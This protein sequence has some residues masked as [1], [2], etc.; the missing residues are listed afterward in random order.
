MYCLLFL[1]FFNV[2]FLFFP[3]SYILG[4]VLVLLHCHFIIIILG[5]I[6][7]ITCLSSEKFKKIGEGGGFFFVN[8]FYKLSNLFKINKIKIT[9]FLF[10]FI[11]FFF[12]FYFLFFLFFIFF[13]I[14]IIF[15]CVNF[16]KILNLMTNTIF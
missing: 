16:C 10:Y 6:K 14:I 3:L 9:F 13:L 5:R 7:L 4:I 11:F 8:V 15:L 1:V 12:F 2:F